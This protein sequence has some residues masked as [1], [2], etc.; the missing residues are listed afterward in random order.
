MR[1]RAYRLIDD[2]GAEVNRFPW[3]GSKTWD[4]EDHAGVEEE[5]DGDDDCDGPAEGD[6]TIEVPYIRS[7][8]KVGRNDPCPCGSGKKHKKCC[9]K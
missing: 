3:Y 2:V 1:N 7:E 8:A 9:G 6:Q 4:E 5:W